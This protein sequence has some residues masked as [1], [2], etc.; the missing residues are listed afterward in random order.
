MRKSLL[1]FSAIALL[2]GPAAAQVAFQTPDVQAKVQSR[3][4]AVDAKTRTGPFQPNWKSLAAYETPDWYRDAKFG[5]FVHWGVYS[6]AAFGTEWY[7]RNM[8]VKGSP[9]YAYHRAAFGPQDKVGYKDLIPKFKAE[10]FD[11]KAWADLFQ[12]AGARY[13]VPVA[14]HCDGFAM[15]DTELSPWNAA[16][17][18][19]KRDVIGEVA[20]A[21]RAKGMHFGLSSHRAEHWWWYE[22]GTK[23]PSDVQD[24][25]YAGLYGP[26][27]P[28]T[29]PGDD[30]E[31]EPEPIHLERWSVPNKAFLDD[32]LARST[33]LVD[34][35]QPE[36]VYLDWWI[37]SPQFAP[38]LQRLA[39]YYY[40]QGKAR[41]QGPVLTYKDEAFPPG[42]ATLDVE[43]GK[44]DLLRL[45]PWQSDTSVSIKSWGYIKDDKYRTA[46][47][48]LVDLIDVVSKNGN[49]LLNVGPKADGTIPEE[50]QAIL[51]EMGDWLKVNGEAIYGTRPWK[52]Y[53]EGTTSVAVGSL[54]EAAQRPYTAADIRFTTKGDILYAMGLVR[55]ADG[56]VTMKTLYAGAPYLERP[57]A[58]VELVGSPAVLQWTQ[59]RDGL[60]VQLPAAAKDM[61][62]ALRIVRAA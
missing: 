40:D 53:G 5:I 21:V 18:G 17:M 14:E 44:L 32:W 37:E 59:G 42:T 1:A 16:R 55:P 2:A 57:I 28:K 13:V 47:S 54:N 10:R 60:H 41:G 4:S 36:F 48:L 31:S 39:A 9:E 61:P 19:P 49:M 50:A 43:R 27:A 46:Q 58:R 51:L 35:Y 11:P 56:R 33:E 62:Y 45:T 30:P 29:L 52:Y 12:K 7:S 8:Y 6:T 23:Y 25:R 22:G 24:P 20:S 3:L 15:Y 34:K 38:Y 26:A